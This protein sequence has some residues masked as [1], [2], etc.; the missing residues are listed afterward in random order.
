MAAEAKSRFSGF[1]DAIDMEKL[2][3]ETQKLFYMGLLVAVSLNV[4]AASFFMFKKT[5]VKVV[6][7]PTMELVIRRPRMTKAFEFKKK[8]VAQ[9]Q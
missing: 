4:A 2:E 3:K 7:P 1:S 9:R 6:K 5:E 8:R